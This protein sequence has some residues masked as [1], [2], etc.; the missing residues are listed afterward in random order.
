M[1]GLIVGC[2]SRILRLFQF[3]VESSKQLKRRLVLS[4]E[5]FSSE[6]SLLCIVLRRSS[7]FS[8]TIG[9]PSRVVKAGEECLLQ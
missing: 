4:E 1:L 5:I 8:V 6:L 3:L 7:C 2:Y 9:R